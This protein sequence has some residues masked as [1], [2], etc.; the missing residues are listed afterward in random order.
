MNKR[1][2]IVLIL[3]TIALIVLWAY[4]F[5]PFAQKTKPRHRVNPISLKTTPRHA[6]VAQESLAFDNYRNRD[7]T[8]NFYTISFP[9]TWQRQVNNIVGGY[10]FT[11]TDGI[12]TSDLMDV[13]DNTTLELFVLSQQEPILKK[14]INGYNR[15]N[16][17]KLSI[18]GN[19]A[20]QLIYRSTLNETDYQTMKDYIV[21]QDQA[22]VITLSTLP[23]SFET[24]QPVFRAVLESFHWENK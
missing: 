12:G 5:G 3:A 8:E 9:Q 1:V 2:G 15:I 18:N 11:F 6:I 24:R 21:G 23:D 16:Y 17:K 19:D 14:T 7:V 4:S 22:A 20:Y 13:P 10:K